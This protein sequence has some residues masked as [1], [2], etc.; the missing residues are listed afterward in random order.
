MR[1]AW[2]HKIQWSGPTVHSST[3]IRYKVPSLFREARRSLIKLHMKDTMT[4]L[5]DSDWEIL[6]AKTEGFSG[7]DLASCVSDAMFEPLREL[8]DAHFWE[9]TTGMKVKFLSNDSLHEVRSR[10]VFREINLY[11]FSDG[12]YI[13]SPKKIKG[14]LELD[15]TEMPPQMVISSNKFIFSLSYWVDNTRG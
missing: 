1:N 14:S 6:A 8:R 7:S 10:M 5:T 3:V 9:I 2:T 4:S 11:S 13:P 12:H 15:I